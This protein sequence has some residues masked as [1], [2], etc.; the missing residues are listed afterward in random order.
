MMRWCL[1]LRGYQYDL[2]YRPGVGDQNDDALSRLPLTSLEDE[3]GGPGDI[4]MIQAMHAPPLTAV[5]I[6]EMTTQGDAL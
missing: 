3:P 4:F 5:D 1:L 2:K 6:A